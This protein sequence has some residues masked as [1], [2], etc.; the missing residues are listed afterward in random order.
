MKYDVLI[1]GGGPAGNYL[2]N[3]L[4]RD[5]SV[6]IVEKKGSFGGKACTG[7][8]G[9]KNYER[10]GFPEEAILNQLRGAVFYS[11][12]QSF[13]IERK[14]PQAYLVNRK[15]LEKALAER[16]VSRGAEYYMATAFQGFKG[17][18][19]ILQ[20]LGERIEVEA[21]F[22]VGADGVSSTVA[23]EMGTKTNAEFLSGYEVEVVGDFKKD[24]V[25]VWINKEINGDFFMWVAP[26]NKGLARVGT[27]GSIEAMNRFLRLRRLKPTSVV[28]F[29]AGSVGLGW[30]KPWVRGNVALLGDAALQIK[31][32]TAGGIVFG[33]I[34]AHALREALL[35]GRLS[36]YEKVCGEIRR[37]ISFGMRFRRIFLGMS[38]DDVE[39]VFEVLG[40]REAREIIEEQ[41]DFDDHVKTA[42]ALLKRPK[43]L[44]K[45]I[46]ISPSIVRYLV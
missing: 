27:L 29:K 28:E 12:I 45:L 15:V 7:I 1:I 26:V 32:T 25:E 5:F 13:E 9:T 34:C 43:L 6:A 23:K 41:A 11:R 21:D 46:R 2:A 38:Q 17:G 16:A 39:R 4:A 33:G 35:S 37:Q 42:K 22:Y 20:H 24:F 10:L 40:S 30:R 18:K 36:D 3:L 44:A 31:P 14:K 19:A 8:I